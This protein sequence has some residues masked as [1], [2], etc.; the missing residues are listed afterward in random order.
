MAMLTR[1]YEHNRPGPSK[2]LAILIKAAGATRHFVPGEG[3]TITIT[4]EL[5]SARRCSEHRSGYGRPKSGQQ[6]HINR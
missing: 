6:Y 4:V 5:E 3:E 2:G 1:R